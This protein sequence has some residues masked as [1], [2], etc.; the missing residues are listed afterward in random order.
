[1]LSDS[2]LVAFVATT[3]ADGAKA[4]YRDRLGLRLVKED[5]IAL[6]FDAGGTK[7]RVQIVAKVAPPP[8]TVLGWEV[9][10]IATTVEGLQQADVRV[11]RFAGIPQD[12]LG[13]WTSTDGTRVAWF[14]DPEGHI[15]SVS[16]FPR[17]GR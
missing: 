8:Y 9:D 6:A 5:P 10:D 15:L 4:F 16:Q 14:K 1:M 2:R 12:E 7:L 13:I 11:E 17:A 3:D